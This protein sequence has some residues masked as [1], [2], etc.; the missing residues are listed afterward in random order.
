MSKRQLIICISPEYSP[1][2][3]PPYPSHTSNFREAFNY[4]IVEQSSREV[5]RK[6]RSQSGKKLRPLPSSSLGPSTTIKRERGGMIVLVSSWLFSYITCY[7][8]IR[9]ISIISITC[10][11]KSL[12]LP[13]PS[14][15]S[16]SCLSFDSLDNHIH[17]MMRSLFLLALLTLL[18][19]AF[20]LQELPLD[21]FERYE[22]S[23]YWPIQLPI[24]YLTV[25]NLYT[26]HRLCWD[27]LFFFCIK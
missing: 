7:D 27:F 13:S 6:R 19:T 23:S 9:S 1:F 25:V 22:R 12:P 20:I 2:N 4:D 26:K 5:D 3:C 18:S 24:M 10:R 21:R 16:H 8:I 15:L 17:R 11:I 14:P